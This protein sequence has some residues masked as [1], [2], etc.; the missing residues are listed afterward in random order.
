M[1]IHVA[2]EATLTLLDN[3]RQ[4][5]GFLIVQLREAVPSTLRDAVGGVELVVDLEVEEQAPNAP[6]SPPESV[7]QDNDILESLRQVVPKIK[8]IVD[9]APE[10]SEVRDD[11]YLLVRC[12]VTLVFFPSFAITQTLHGELC[13]WRIRYEAVQ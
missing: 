9:V 6:S 8:T 2:T 1:S 5:V 11:L 4:H 10:T 3:Q 7:Q 12:E 13:F